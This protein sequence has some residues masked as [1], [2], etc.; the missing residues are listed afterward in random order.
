RPGR[1]PCPGRVGSARRCP[2][3]AAR[4]PRPLSAPPRPRPA[5]LVTAFLTLCLVWGST[6][7]VIKEGARDLPPFTAAAVRFAIAWVIMLGIARPLARIE[8]GARPG[9]D[10]VAITGGLQ[11]ATS[12]AIVYWAETILPSGLT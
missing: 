2:H 6:W 4:L 8:G 12:Y 9:L 11:F 1:A 7:F 10:L 5:L 3:P